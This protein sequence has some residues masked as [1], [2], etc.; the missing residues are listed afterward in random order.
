MTVRYTDPKLVRDVR[1]TEIP[2]SGHTASGYGGRIPTQY[3][4]KYLGRWRRVYSMVYGNSG[5]PYIQVG[6]Q[7]AHLDI[8]TTYRLE[9]V[10]RAGGTRKVV[11]VDTLMP[12]E[13]FQFHHDG[14]VNTI[15]WP[16]V[17]TSF[18]YHDYTGEHLSIPGSYSA[19]GETA[20][21][22]VYP[23]DEPETTVEKWP[24]Q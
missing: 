4:L 24:G 21:P 12:G 7:P 2:L 22:Y 8:D 20:W 15:I 14:V 16:G 23:T 3:M 11:S 6:G 9:V 18:K 1:I 17:G 19:T 5:S 13:R 10:N